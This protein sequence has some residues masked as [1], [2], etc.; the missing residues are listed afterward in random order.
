MTETAAEPGRRT[1]L[2]A[3]R[4]PNHGAVPPRSY[5]LAS[6]VRLPWLAGAALFGLLALGTALL[7][8]R[9]D[10]GLNVPDAVREAQE[11]VTT[12]A[13]QSARRSVNEGVDDL[14]QA[15]TALQALPP[16]ANPEPLVSSVMEAH[17]RFVGVHLLEA[18]GRD[19]VTGSGTPVRIDALGSGTLVGSGALDAVQARGAEVPVIY[20]YASVQRAGRP[21]E[22][23]VGEYDA[24]FLR[25]PLDVAQPGSAW[26]VN[27]QSR[28]IA[29]L[30]GFQ[31]FQTLG[32]QVL[33]DAA[34]NGSSG[35]SGSRVTD[36][37]LDRSEVLAWAPVA[38]NGPA[39]ALGWS[40][41]TARSVDTIALPQVDFRRQAILVG[42]LVALL[43]LLVF[44]WLW[45]VVYRP[46]A[47][48][49]RE[50]E[51]IAFGD[52]SQAVEIVRYDEIGLTA[53]ALERV[54]VILIRK[55]VQDDTKP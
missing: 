18:A 4:T 32:R 27:K 53:R 45:I 13:A 34:D 29:A 1:R 41:V 8:G 10:N 5:R 55:R 6:S 51:R 42:L 16:E 38:G 11:R 52:L 39:G 50:A 24:G 23:L 33:R 28:V 9:V 36:V 31:A 22:V 3:R 40:V 15:A 54:R 43:T 12:N 25:F 35:A 2:R 17:A 19:V 46:L 20:L 26:M 48:L 14:R 7:V 49:Q 44:G 30:D 37:S 47:R 21:A